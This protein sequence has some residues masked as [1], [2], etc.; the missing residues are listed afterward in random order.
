MDPGLDTSLLSNDPGVVRAYEQDPLVHSHATVRF[1]TESL[2]AIKRINRNLDQ[3]QVPILFLHGAQDHL[4]TVEGARQAFRKLGLEAKQFRLY[5][6]SRHE[7]HND[8]DRQ[9]VAEDVIRWIDAHL[10]KPEAPH[11][12]PHDVNPAAGG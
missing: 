7:P 12:S 2:A 8:L 9:A 3:I 6:N 1:A 10:T 4:T 5:E 11:D